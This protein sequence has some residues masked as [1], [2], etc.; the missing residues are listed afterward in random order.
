[1]K[2]SSGKKLF[3]PSSPIKVYCGG[4]KYCGH[5]VNYDLEDAEARLSLF[6]DGSS[7]KINTPRKNT[8]ERRNHQCNWQDIVCVH[9][10][11]EIEFRLFQSVLREWECPYCKKT[12]H[13]GIITH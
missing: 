4:G 13:G 3:L 11:G 5:S 12:L 1:V 2:T 10:R 8:T 6:C 7:N 9:C